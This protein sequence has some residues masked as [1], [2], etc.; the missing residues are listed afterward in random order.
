MK[1]ISLNDDFNYASMYLA[2]ECRELK[3]TIL[4]LYKQREYFIKARTY[5]I[6]A[7][8]LYERHFAF[9]SKKCLTI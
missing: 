5:R 3:Y 1:I 8:I 4:K 6:K 2:N 9:N 7:L